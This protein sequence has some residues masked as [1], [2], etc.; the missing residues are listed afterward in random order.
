MTAHTW[1]LYAVF[2]DGVKVA[3]YAGYEKWDGVNEAIWRDGR[4][5]LGRLVPPG[6]RI[7]QDDMTIFEL[8]MPDG[9]RYR[10]EL[11]GHYRSEYPRWMPVK[12]VK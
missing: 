12:L 11:I 4:V 6:T 2:V 3:E 10:S 5:P 7:T 8:E 9:V 1:S